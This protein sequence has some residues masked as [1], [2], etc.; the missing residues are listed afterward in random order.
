M[1]NDPILNV[2]SKDLHVIITYNPI[3]LNVK[4][5]LDKYW[6]VINSSRQLESIHNRKF[7]VGHRHETNLQDIHVRARIRYPLSIRLNQISGRST[8]KMLYAN[9]A[10]I[11]KKY[12]KIKENQ[13]T[14]LDIPVENIGTNGPK[15][16]GEHT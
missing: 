11:P 9:F 7:I 3:N 13:R 6:P 14:S 2:Q 4:S 12:H 8:N 10:T 5:T 15:Q 16:H 1:S